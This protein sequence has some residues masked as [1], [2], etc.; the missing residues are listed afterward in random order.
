MF[1]NT[2]SEI[3][4]MRL[5]IITKIIP[6]EEKR[7]IFKTEF[8]RIINEQHQKTIELYNYLQ[9]QILESNFTIY[10]VK[11]M[12][13][14][15]SLAIKVYASEV[16]LNYVNI[17]HQVNLTKSNMITSEY[18]YVVKWVG[19]A[20]IAALSLFTLARLL[21]D[22]DLLK[23]AVGFTKEGSTLSSQTTE[24]LHVTQQVMQ[25]ALGVTTDL[26]LMSAVQVGNTLGQQTN[27]LSQYMI[28]LVDKIKTLTSR[29]D[30][31]E[32]AIKKLQQTT[33]LH[34]NWIEQTIDA[35]KKS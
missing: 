15:E 27:N 24:S 8:M 9:Q 16:I 35:S 30:C 2:I 11:L 26:G 19:I 4:N 33:L 22:T 10:D 14:K 32:E 23:K 13:L 28:S 31:S 21:N 17:F 1:R 6:L 18:L 29:I 25:D 34:K 3:Y 20:L 5:F 7:V 12:E